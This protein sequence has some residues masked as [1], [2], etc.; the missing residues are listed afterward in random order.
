MHPE[1]IQ[2][3]FQCQL[4]PDLALRPEWIRVDLQWRLKPDL[5]IVSETLSCN[6]MVGH[7]SLKKTLAMFRCRDSITGLHYFLTVRR[8]LV[9]LT[10]ILGAILPIHW[11][12]LLD[13]FTSLVDN[14]Q[15]VAASVSKV[16]K[17][18]GHAPNS[19]H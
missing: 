6:D 14:R 17:G 12:V 2:V 19:A 9:S 13:H 4:K 3:D 7:S 16:W 1:W 8:L 18:N 10:N 11:R 15:A 5:T